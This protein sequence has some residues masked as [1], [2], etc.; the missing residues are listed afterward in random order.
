MQ[1]FSLSKSFNLENTGTVE[2]GVSFVWSC[3][4][5]LRWAHSLVFYLL[6]N[7]VSTRGFLPTVIVIRLSFMKLW[8]IA[9]TTTSTTMTTS[10][11]TT[12]AT[13]KWKYFSNEKYRGRID[14]HIKEKKICRCPC[15]GKR[16]KNAFRTGERVRK[17]GH[18]RTNVLRINRRT[19]SDR[20]IPNESFQTHRSEQTGSQ[21]VR[22]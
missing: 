15:R 19:R 16:V 18:L 10:A 9:L 6:S 5:L 11:T 20:L 8:L 21:H 13:S 17:K 14:F 22:P 12:T 7:C 2:V 3:L 1:V 4:L